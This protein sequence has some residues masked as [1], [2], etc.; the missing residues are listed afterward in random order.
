ML[1]K[2]ATE[3]NP[4][5]VIN[6]GSVAGMRPQGANNYAYPASKA[7]LHMLTR[8]LAAVLC[9]QLI[10][11]NA[12]APG[13]IDVGIAARSVE[14][15]GLDAVVSSVPM[16]RLGRSSEIAATAVYLASPAAAYITGAVLPVDGGI[17]AA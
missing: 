11:V 3:L 9:E 15:L 5:R 17:S 8:Q 12:I 16:G 1:Q 7:A 4:S 6:I 10:T 14:A 2:N 13:P